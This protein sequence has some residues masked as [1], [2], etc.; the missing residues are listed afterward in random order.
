MGIVMN[1][2]LNYLVSGTIVLM[3]IF[4][5]SISVILINWV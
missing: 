5:W 1:T 3:G 2:M 4:L